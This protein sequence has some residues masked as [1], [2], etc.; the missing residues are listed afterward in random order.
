MTYCENVKIVIGDMGSESEDVDGDRWVL[1]LAQK[2][3]KSVSHVVI[4]WHPTRESARKH[5]RKIR[6]SMYGKV[7][8]KTL[9]K[10]GCG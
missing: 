4:A 8:R 3:N 10:H 9:R 5:A 2:K 6:S 1:S 7:D